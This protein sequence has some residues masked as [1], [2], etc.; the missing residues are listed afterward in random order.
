[1]EVYHTNHDDIIELKGSFDYE[2]YQV[3][4]R[5]FFAHINEP[6]VTFNNYKFYPNTACINQFP[7]VG[8]VQALINMERK[9]LALRPCE[10]H[11]RDSFQWCNTTSGRRKPKQMTCRLFFAKVFAMMEWNMDH[12]YRLLGKVIR[13]NGE[14]LIAFDLTATEVYQRISKNGNKPKT[15]RIPVFPAHWQEQFGLPYHE[16]SKSMQINIFEGYAVYGIK[17]DQV[18]ELNCDTTELKTTNLER[19]GDDGQ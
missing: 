10:E 16:H 19:L 5:E 15:S 12:R 9:I 1:M 4:R 7:T 8:Y 13:A 17:N 3:V 11:D 14:S 2:G 18:A 6:S